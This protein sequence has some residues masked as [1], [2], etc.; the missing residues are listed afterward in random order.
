MAAESMSR[1]VLEH[2]QNQ[3]RPT[4]LQSI[5]ADGSYPWKTV[6]AASPDMTDSTGSTSATSSISSTWQTLKR[7]SETV[8]RKKGKTAR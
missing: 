7:R 6:S 3:E 4:Y 8:A 1:I 5:N 2:L